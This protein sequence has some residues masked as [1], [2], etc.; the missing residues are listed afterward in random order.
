MQHINWKNISMDIDVINEK[1]IEPMSRLSSQSLCQ[2]QDLN[3]VL[4]DTE[5]HV[6][7]KSIDFFLNDNDLQVPTQITDWGG[8]ESRR[9]SQG[10]TAGNQLSSQLMLCVL[11]TLVPFA[12]NQQHVSK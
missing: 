12:M 8:V 7:S 1:N 10:H 4:S 6:T 9:Y 2:S 11:S 5:G 3:P